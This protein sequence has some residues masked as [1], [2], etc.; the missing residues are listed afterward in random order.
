MAAP[1][2]PPVRIAD[3]EPAGFRRVN[4]VLRHLL[5]SPVA[6][7]VPLPLVL[8]RVT[9]RRSGRQIETPVGLHR[10]GEQDFVLSR[11]GWRHN[12]SGGAPVEVVQRGQVRRGTGTLVE[13][14]AEAGRR[15]LAL[16]EQGT[17]PRQLGLAVDKGHH[18]TMEELT[19]TG[20]S[21]IDLRLD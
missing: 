13:G 9:G 8:L 1:A 21:I 14:P 18:A 6:R 17:S 3:R 20:A 19:A 5:S 2:V 7:V 12:L 15:M 10:I 11:A 16:I 4:A